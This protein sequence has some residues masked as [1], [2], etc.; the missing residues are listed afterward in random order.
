MQ[1]ED[2]VHSRTSAS[3]SSSSVDDSISIQLPT[4]LSEERIFFATLRKQARRHHEKTISQSLVPSLSLMA[5]RVASR[6]PSCPLLLA[7]LR[8][9][10]GAVLYSTSS[11]W[12]LIRSMFKAI[13]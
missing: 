2:F 11:A 13:G 9:T 6:C 1:Q 4:K 8:V 5:S 3:E 7:P 12:G 10:S